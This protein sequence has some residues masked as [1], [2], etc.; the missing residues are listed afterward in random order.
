MSKVSL[1]EW[2]IAG[3]RNGNRDEGGH[4]RVRRGRISQVSRARRERRAQSVRTDP[5]F[6]VSSGASAALRAAVQVLRRA[7]GEAFDIGKL[8]HQVV[9]QRLSLRTRQQE[10]LLLLC[11]SGGCVEVVP[12]G[13][14]PDCLLASQRAPPVCVCIATVAHLSRLHRRFAQPCRTESG[15]L[16]FACVQTRASAFGHVCACHLSRCPASSRTV[17]W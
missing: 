17:V 6:C 4:H 11:A 12:G 7:A 9:G 8:G 15:R 3:H 1:A 14:L 13:R 2:L 16:R 5:P 10:P